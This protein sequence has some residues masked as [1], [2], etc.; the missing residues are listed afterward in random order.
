MAVMIVVVTVGSVL[1]Q[2]AKIEI[3][4][5]IDRRW[6]PHATQAF[7]MGGGL[8]NTTQKVN[9]INTDTTIKQVC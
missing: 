8:L 4:H 3:D 5:S 1:I 7:S 6:W 2:V 9:N